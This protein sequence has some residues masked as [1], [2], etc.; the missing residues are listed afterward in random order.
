MLGREINCGERILFT[1][2]KGFRVRQIEATV[3]DVMGDILAVRSDDNEPFLVNKFDVDAVLN[4]I[5]EELTMDEDVE[6]EDNSS[7][8]CSDR[9]I[10]SSNHIISIQ[11]QLVENPEDIKM[12]FYK[13]KY[14]NNRHS[15][16]IG[17]YFDTNI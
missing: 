1:V 15:G 13:N 9:L 16:G 10:N 8:G 7:I 2:R 4:Q 17:G 3:N 5:E 14:R 12:T 11:K 6:D